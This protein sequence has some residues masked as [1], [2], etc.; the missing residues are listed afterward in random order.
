[1]LKKTPLSPRLPAAL[2]LWCA[3]AFLA[4]PLHAQLPKIFVASSGN[5]ANDGSRNAPKRNF[6]AAHDAVA[7]KGQIVVLDTAGYATLNITK[8]ISVIVPPGVNGFVTVPAGA[9][10][11]TIAAGGSGVVALRGL[12][13]ESGGSG[14]G[15]GILATSVGTLTIE[16]CTVRNFTQGIYVLSTTNAQVSLYQ[17]TVRSCS[18]GLDV[19]TNAAIAVV[20][21]ATGCRVENCSSSGVFGAN[22]TGGSV[23]LTLEGCT[24]RGNNNG[25]SMQSASASV[26]MSDCTIT[27]N[28]NGVGTSSG[29]QLLSRGN[30]TLEKNTN[31]NTFPG[32]YSAK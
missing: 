5:D 1:M 25:V 23:D 6:Q 10:G 28:N 32:A 11:I 2:I 29:S 31:G 13:V 20:A 16:D 17:T 24:V 14:G 8:S 15:N 12:I 7:A 27:G 3:L 26:R 22:F 21:S 19:Q 9:S 18:F 30:N 4:G